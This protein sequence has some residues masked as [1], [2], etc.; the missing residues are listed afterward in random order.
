LGGDRTEKC[1]TE[2]GWGGR[3]GLK[4]AFLALRNFWTTLYPSCRFS[5][6]CLFGWYLIW[7]L[8]ACFRSM[9]SWSS[10][11]GVPT[12][13][14]SQVTLSESVCEWHREEKYFL[15]IT[16]EHANT[17]ENRTSSPRNT[18]ACD[19]DA[20]LF[21]LL[22]TFV[23]TAAQSVLKYMWVSWKSQFWKNFLFRARGLNC[24]Y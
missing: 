6:F 19:R 21:K 10:P 17:P 14:A 24:L 8:W 3:V 4:F 22:C 12:V 11:R 20:R 15:T 7:L 2:R 1:V 18:W 16:G 5:R 23:R 13:M 9:F